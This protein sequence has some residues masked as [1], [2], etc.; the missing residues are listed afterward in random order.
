MSDKKR[1]KYLTATGNNQSELMVELIGL[2]LYGAISE[3]KI[4]TQRRIYSYEIIDQTVILN[5]KGGEPDIEDDIDLLELIKVFLALKQIGV[6]VQVEGL[7]GGRFPDNDFLAK[8]KVRFLDFEAPLSL[9]DLIEIRKWLIGQTKSIEELLKDP[10]FCAIFPSVQSK[11][12]EYGF[13]RHRSGTEI[14]TTWKDKI[15]I[16]SHG[17]EVAYPLQ[18]LLD[19]FVKLKKLDYDVDDGFNR[20]RSNKWKLARMLGR[21]G[22]EHKQKVYEWVDATQFAIEEFHDSHGRTYTPET[23]ECYFGNSVITAD[24][25]NNFDL[26]E[27]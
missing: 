16:A 26:I 22:Q 7:W 14:R 13:I 9:E 5:I 23:F 25:N 15:Y 20:Y 4:R 21:V 12:G 24:R 8:N 6:E 19:V 11:W 3:S 2:C 27:C 1:F 10:A 17:Y 18:E